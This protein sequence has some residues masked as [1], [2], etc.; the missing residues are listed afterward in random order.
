MRGV[1]LHD[2]LRGGGDESTVTE[3]TVEVVESMRRNC[4]ETLSQRAGK[5]GER[6]RALR[7]G[8]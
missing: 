8:R 7:R 2:F 5:P 3:P 1:D 6:V 4:G